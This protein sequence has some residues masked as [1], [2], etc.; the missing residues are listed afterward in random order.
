M[1]IKKIIIT[2]LIF[3]VIAFGFYIYKLHILAIEGNKIFEYRCTNVN[4]PLIFYKNSFLKIADSANNLKKYSAD[5][6]RGF[7]ADYLS[8][9]QK[10]VE[11]ENKWLEMQKKF[12]NRWDFQL[13]APW[14]LKKAYEYQWKMYEG[15]R[16]DAK[17]KLDI[18]EITDFDNKKIVDEVMNRNTEARERLSNYS[19]L[20]S[21]LFDKAVK[22]KD[23]RKTFGQVPVSNVCTDEN[24]TIPDTGGSINWYGQPPSPTPKQVPIYQEL[25]S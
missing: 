25:T 21:D 10:Y 23:W 22:I 4:P 11:E 17:A 20:Y 13:I 19:K 24:L 1:S 16:D 3:G 18:F 14:Y 15:Y 6:V 12:G 2:L 9:M 5:E 7:Y 8:G